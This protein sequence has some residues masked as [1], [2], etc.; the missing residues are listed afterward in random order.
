MR[1]VVAGIATLSVVCSVGAVPW[2]APA[3]AVSRA[4]V[5][6][7]GLDDPY[8]L[9]F[10]PDGDLYV[11]ESG[12]G[13]EGPCVDETEGPDGDPGPVCFGA[14][15][16]VTR[17]VDGDGAQSR[18]LEGLP[19]IAGDEGATGPS[20][21]VV[22]ADGSLLVTVGLG[23]NVTSRAA[24]GPDAAG[25]GTVLRA[26]PDTG[27]TTVYADLAAFEA[28]ED[29]DAEQPGSE[30]VGE[31]GDSNPF[32]AELVGDELYVVDAGGNTLVR[33]GADAVELVSVFPVTEAPAP[34]FIGAPPGTVIPSQ[35][36]PT[37]VTAAPDGTLHV[38]E[39]TGFPFPA[40]GAD[41]FEV[42]ESG[43]ETV[44]FSGFTHIM[45]LAYDEAG[46]LY[47][48]QLSRR[49]LLEGD[50]VPKVVQVRPDGTRK[51]LLD[52]A[53]LGGVPTGLAVGPDGLLYV[54]LGLAG[55]GGGRVVRVDPD[56][57]RD[58]ASASAC[59]PASVPGTGFGDL[60]DT[61]HREAIECLSWW[62]VVS[63]VSAERFAP[64][65]AASRGAVAT[66]LTKVLEAAGE[67]LPASP[68]DA[69]TDDTDSP[70][71]L[72]IN[73]LAA[74]GLV[75]GF[76]DGTFR[77]TQMVTR[78]QVATLMVQAYEAFFGDL[79]PGGNAFVDD[80]GSVHEVNIN[81]AFAAGWVRGRTL[82]RFE[83]QSGAQRDQVATVLVRMLATLV[84]DGVATP[85]ATAG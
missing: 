44:A 9:S 73:Q 47:V 63:G 19:S 57:A 79:R 42:P 71:H 74:L 41:V 84:D 51:T 2:A 23:G 8:K 18:V 50:P 29:P 32:G 76:G 69:F 43:E 38:G 20:D 62:D 72:R 17:V 45:D 16:A 5:V 26:A 54:S 22:G 83:P 31:G 66:M 28:A 70:H 53:Q 59:P 75:R 21:V 27:D 36:V 4:E 6:A 46:N 64:E 49:S 60:E 52:A 37:T 12:R 39:L 35:S 48:A 81:A 1:R 24:F 25:L 65:V 55:P 40:G 67:T 85:P 11:A 82:T 68:P 80:T 33:A 14:S 30:S 58:A 3:G 34:P 56:I 77:P 7:R 13:G 15:G 78:G 61:V 10:G